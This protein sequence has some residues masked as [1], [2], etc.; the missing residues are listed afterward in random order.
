MTTYNIDHKLVSACS[1]E[2]VSVSMGRAG[3]RYVLCDVVLKERVSGRARFSLYW[4]RRCAALLSFVSDGVPKLTLDLG[5][6]CARLSL[7]VSKDVLNE[8]LNDALC[9]LPCIATILMES[10]PSME[11]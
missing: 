9:A 7:S 11:L 10:I 8:V 3:K 1:K 6:P 2:F 5:L 4:R